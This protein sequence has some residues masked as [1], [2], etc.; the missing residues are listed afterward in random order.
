VNK[1]NTTGVRFENCRL[2]RYGSGPAVVTRDYLEYANRGYLNPNLSDW[3]P[4]VLS[5]VSIVGGGI[6]LPVRV[7]VYGGRNILFSNVTVSNNAAFLISN[8]T[9]VTIQD[10]VLIGGGIKFSQDSRRVSIL[11]SHFLDFGMFNYQGEERPVSLTWNPRGVG[12]IA[13]VSILNC[14]FSN[15]TKTSNRTNSYAAIHIGR[16]IEAPFSISNFVRLS[17]CFG[18][19]SVVWRLIFFTRSFANVTLVT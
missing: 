19:S 13:D 18:L 10:S 1:R 7:G 16:A 17:Y 3:A 4:F 12:N 5:D 14:K 15:Y 8:S 2:T 11:N 9:G 6:H